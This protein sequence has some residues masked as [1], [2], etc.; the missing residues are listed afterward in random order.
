MAK[1]WCILQMP[2]SNVLSG[3][4]NGLRSSIFQTVRKLYLAS[5]LGLEIGGASLIKQHI[6]VLWY[7][8]GVMLQT[9]LRNYQ[10]IKAHNRWGLFYHECLFVSEILWV[11]HFVRQLI[12]TRSKK[13]TKDFFYSKKHGEE[14][15]VVDDRFV[16]KGE[17]RFCLKLS[18]TLKS[19]DMSGRIQCFASP[20]CKGPH[21]VHPKCMAQVPLPNSNKQYQVKFIRIKRI[22]YYIS[23]QINI[24]EIGVWFPQIN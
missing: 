1:R 10:L 5:I 23:G 19:Q 24:W 9:Y 4:K 6:G 14:F 7:L 21:K 2:C 16:R 22:S 3:Q 8:L 18:V 17:F 12:Q 13:V 11:F 15:F 20:L